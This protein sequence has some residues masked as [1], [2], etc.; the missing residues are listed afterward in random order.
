MKES[1]LLTILL[2]IAIP[3]SSTTAS[4]N[5]ISL[6]SYVRSGTYLYISTPII[7]FSGT[8]C[9][10]VTYATPF[11]SGTTVKLYISPIEFLQSIDL[12]SNI[13]SIFIYASD[14]SRLATSIGI[15]TMVWPYI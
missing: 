11:A 14:N 3:A 6:A 7:I 10:T 9:T 5:I 12:N 8:S 4:P 2:L 1:F 13:D 15:C